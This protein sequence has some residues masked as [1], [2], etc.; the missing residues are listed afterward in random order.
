MFGHSVCLASA[1]SRMQAVNLGGHSLD[2]QSAFCAVHFWSS[3]HERFF[4]DYA[5]T[6]HRGTELLLGQ[7]LPPADSRRCASPHKNG[8][9]LRLLRCRT[10][11]VRRTWKA[12][13]IGH[14]WRL[15]PDTPVFVGLSCVRYGLNEPCSAIQPA[16][17]CC[18]IALSQVIRF[19]VPPLLTFVALP[20]PVLRPVAQGSPSQTKEY[21]GVP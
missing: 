4:G 1:T 17:S 11:R 20:I 8:L 19:W 2:A 13:D 5:D 7:P 6:G 18:E 3:G 14:R 12:T 21:A 16:V 9:L 10:G 15:R